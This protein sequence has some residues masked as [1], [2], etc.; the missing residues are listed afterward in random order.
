MNFNTSQAHLPRRSE[1]A[2]HE[3]RD[4]ILYP[5]ELNLEQ[6]GTSKRG[7]SDWL[8]NDF[9]HLE[10]YNH[11]EGGDEVLP[12]YGESG[13]ENEYDDET[14]AKLKSEGFQDTT[15]KS[16][17]DAQAAIF[18]NTTAP[19]RGKRR[20]AA[21][22]PPDARS[23]TRDSAP[24]TRRRPRRG[25]APSYT[26]KA[27]TRG[28]KSRSDDEDSDDG[29]TISYPPEPAQKASA[30]PTLFQMERGEDLDVDHAAMPGVGDGELDVDLEAELE[31]ALEDAPG[32]GED[33]SE[34]EEE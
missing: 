10:K 27:P 25:A 30:A 31:Q 19:D 16:L 9:D 34:S 6:S 29:L 20:R 24:N 8:N 11:L 26:S 7:V 32:G 2:I 3:S 12:L 28:P 18:K 33:S 5:H 1:S 4:S 15:T 13:S 21:P 14:W 17:N 22:E 23:G